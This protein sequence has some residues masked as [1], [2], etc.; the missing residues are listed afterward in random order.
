MISTQRVFRV[1]APVAIGTLVLLLGACGATEDPDEPDDYSIRAHLTGLTASGL[2]LQYNGSGSIPVAAGT[3]TATITDIAVPGSTYAVTIL[4]QPTGQ[5]CSVANGSGTANTD[6][7]SITIVCSAPL[8]I[9]G[10]ITGLTG[11]GLTLRLNGQTGA[12]FNVNPAPGAPTFQFPAGVASGSTYAVGVAAQPTNPAQSCG[13]TG[14]TG[15]GTVGT[16][17]VTNV[18]INCVTNGPF[19][20]GGTISGLTQAGLS[21]R[22][23][24]TA[25]PGAAPSVAV[26]NVAADAPSFAFTEIVPASGVFDVGIQTQPA[27]QSCVLVRGKG[28]SPIN[29]TNVGVSC[30]S[31]AASALVGPYT[32]LI[33]PDA[34]ASG[35]RVYANF[36]ADG[37]F[38][39]ASALYEPGCNTA[40]DT[41]NGNGVEYGI[42]TWDAASR[43]LSLQMPAVID[44][45][46]E[47]VF[48]NG[49]VATPNMSVTKGAGTITYQETGGSPT[50][51]AAIAS[52]NPMTLVEGAYVR[53]AGNGQLLVLHGDNT[54]MLAETQGRGAARLNTQERGCYVVSGAQITFT[55]DAGCR[56][57]GLNSYDF[58]GPYGFGPFPSSPSIGP[59]S[60]SLEGSTVLV[61]NGVRWK[62]SIAN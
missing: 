15:S 10:S 14:G 52:P 25:T 57:D 6:I 8:L 7:D 27:N 60:F 56:P 49:G 37:T 18:T 22:M 47:C 3:T 51:L 1:V 13:P 42:F 62:R 23:Y 4:A 53:E 21:L 40:T 30:I 48:A 43:A 44:T 55:V 54:F 2:V 28:S 17:N 19:T 5:V 59:L 24:Y 36:N 45:S 16:A 50:V 38:T 29:V 58:N 39:T 35:G 20:V 11:S 32:V 26:V 41:G 33:P 61:L 12:T 46:G 9:G 31:N 34:N